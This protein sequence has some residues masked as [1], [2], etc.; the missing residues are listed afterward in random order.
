MPRR[1]FHFADILLNR[2]FFGEVG[3]SQLFI[4]REDAKIDRLFPRYRQD[5]D[6]CI[7]AAF[8]VLAMKLRQ[9]HPVELIPGEDHVMAGFSGAKMHQ[10]FA[11][12]IGGTLVPAAV[13]ERLFRCKDL[14][15]SFGKA[16]KDIRVVDVQ[17]QRG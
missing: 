12:R 8:Y 15:K 16:V 5:G 6:T 17:V 9:V 13:V 3:N 10:V 11:N 2:R 14:Y 4:Q 1:E 7:R